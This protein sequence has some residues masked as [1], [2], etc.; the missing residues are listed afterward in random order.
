MGEAKNQSGLRART[1]VA[2]VLGKPRL[3]VALETFG[4]TLHV[5]GD[6]QA[7]VTPLGQLPFFIEFLQVSGLFE[8][9]VQQ[10]PLT[11]I[12]RR[13]QLFRPSWSHFARA[14]RIRSANA[15]MS[16]PGWKRAPLGSP[17]PEKW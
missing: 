15:G 13:N 16:L 7:A 14:R 2:E 10:C 1:A 5:Q 6:P 9:F 17:M 3:P 4:G 11:V 12:V 8:R